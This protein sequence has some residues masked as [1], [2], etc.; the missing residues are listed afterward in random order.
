MRVAGC[1]GMSRRDGVDMNPVG[2]ELAGERLCEGCHAGL[3]GAVDR[4]RGDAHQAGVTSTIPAQLT[5]MSTGPKASST[6][7]AIRSTS[8]TR[9][10]SVRKALAVPP[11]RSI[12]LMVR[13]SPVSNAGA[14]LR[15][16]LTRATV[17]P[18]ADRLL[19]DR[20]DLIDGT[21]A[22]PIGDS[23][24]LIEGG[25]I[26]YAGPRTAR[27]DD[28]AAVRVRLAGKTLIPGLI[29]AHT[30]SC[31]DADMLAY[32]KNGITTIRFAG[33]EQGDVVKL[34]DRVERGA[35]IGPCILSCGPMID[36]PPVAYPE[37]TAPVETPREAA[38]TAERLIVEDAVEYLILTQRVTAPVMRAVVEIAH[39]HGRTVVTQ[40]WA[41]DGRE[42]A[43]LGID[44]VH[45][46]SR[47]FISKAYPAA[48]LTDYATIAERLA[49]TGRGWATIDWDATMPL[50]DAMIERGV[51]C[52]GMHV[53]AQL[54]VGERVAE[55]EADADFQEIFDDA[56]R[57]AFRDFV[58]RLSG[59]WTAEDVTWWERA[60]EARMEWLRRFRALGGQ[61]LVG[62]DTQFSGIMLHR[63]LANIAA[64]SASPLEVI[65]MASSGNARAM[66]LDEIGTIGAGKRADIVVLNRNPLADLGA[67]RDI[68]T[69]IKDGAVLWR[70]PRDESSAEARH[71]PS[72]F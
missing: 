65:T 57:T 26:A 43:E 63:E 41:L 47:I 51:P 39:A 3:G 60:N 52:C 44:E 50:M 15:P 4:V 5:R 29:E 16:G 37:W 42:V 53:I 2:C 58:E 23:M 6:P 61:L 45:N 49:L 54:L 70:R 27:F 8:A 32:V 31:F 71:F 24:V 25:R 10:T 7:V 18:M 21:G 66:R 34:R 30:H 48:Q 38:A 1:R 20:A 59:M 9:A 36:L 11:L 56:E 22:P 62:T 64:L 33:L 35:L 12:A 40:S 67:L 14:T 13:A 17:D 28:D 69:V 46:T 19:L 68:E 72:A 55:L